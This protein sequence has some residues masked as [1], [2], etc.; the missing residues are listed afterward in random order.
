M[1]ALTKERIEL[2]Q[3]AQ[4]RIREATA[5]INKAVARTAIE[6]RVNQKLIPALLMFVDQPHEGSASLEELIDEIKLEE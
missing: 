5:L 1:N 6:A 3:K 2:L 4:D